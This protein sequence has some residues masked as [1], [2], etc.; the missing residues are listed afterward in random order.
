MQ[1]IVAGDT[2]TR[3]IHRSGDAGPDGRFIICGAALD[4]P[5]AFRASYRD[6]RGARTIVKWTDELEV[7]TITLHQGQP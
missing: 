4:Q 5:M 6:A 3:P 2:L 1:T 7:I